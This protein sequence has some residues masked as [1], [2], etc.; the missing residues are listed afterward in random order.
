MNRV[1]IEAYTIIEVVVTI[2]ITSIIILL[3][4]TVYSSFLKVLNKNL[5]SMQD[6]IELTLFNNQLSEDFKI[7]EKIFLRNEKLVFQKLDSTEIS[8][9]FLDD[10]IIRYS[11][12]FEDT[13]FIKHHNV[14]FHYYFDN[15]IN[16]VEFDVT[17]ESNKFKYYIYKDYN[18]STLVN[19]NLNNGN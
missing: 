9:E 10:L 3:S 11:K 18:N 13:H 7:S 6:N 16:E 2:L 15:L 4:L 14:E 1:R 5:Q 12:E 17:T 19:L 8:Y